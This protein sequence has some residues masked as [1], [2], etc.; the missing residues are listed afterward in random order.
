MRT[1][2]YRKSCTGVDVVKYAIDRNLKMMNTVGSIKLCNTLANKILSS[3]V[4]GEFLLD[5]CRARK[6]IPDA[7]RLSIYLGEIAEAEQSGVN[8][9]FNSLRE[10]VRCLIDS[11]AM[12]NYVADAR[13]KDRYNL[14]SEYTEYFK[15]AIALRAEKLG[16]IDC[17]K[18]AR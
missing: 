2:K 11:C 7:L 5:N 17:L 18:E 4:Y 10:R 16:V 14:N 12:N 3:G 8:L 6:K 1:D 9:S 13:M 15:M